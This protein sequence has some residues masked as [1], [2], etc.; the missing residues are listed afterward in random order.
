VLA[1]VRPSRATGP[2][3]VPGMLGRADRRTGFSV[4]KYQANGAM[5]TTTIPVAMLT[6][7]GVRSM[8]RDEPEESTPLPCSS[9]ITRPAVLTAS[10]R[11]AYPCSFSCLPTRSQ[12][13]SAS[14][15][16]QVSSFCQIPQW[17]KGQ[18]GQLCQESETPGLERFGCATEN[19]LVRVVYCQ[20]GKAA[21]R[22]AVCPC[23]GPA[24][25]LTSPSR[26]NPA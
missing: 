19:Q 26:A 5:T 6:R 16:P 8:R 12:T 23:V 25:Y 22:R 11:L 21:K 13:R 9:R 18:D 4:G 1:A 7:W 15:P 24:S 17:G 14:Q 3:P 2:G 10:S 20:I